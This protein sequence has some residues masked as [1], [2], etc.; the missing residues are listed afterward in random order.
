M[1]VTG[2][3]GA[4]CE[5][6]AWLRLTEA[7][8]RCPLMTSLTDLPPQSRDCWSGPELAAASSHH[9]VTVSSSG[10]VLREQVRPVL[11]PSGLK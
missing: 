4:T 6:E 8:S 3:G 11:G 9:S 2:G 10:W 5:G 7:K 1:K